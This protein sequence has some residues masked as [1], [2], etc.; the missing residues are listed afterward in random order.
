MAVSYSAFSAGLEKRRSK[1]QESA[2]AVPALY[3]VDIII[4]FPYSVPNDNWP[5]RSANAFTSNHILRREDLHQDSFG[6]SLS[7]IVLSIPPQTHQSL[8][9]YTKVS[10]S[11]QAALCITLCHASS[12]LVLRSRPLPTCWRSTKSFSTAQAQM[13]NTRKNC[14]TRNSR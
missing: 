6:T 8:R 14:G 11:E 4:R 2:L 7:E 1:W 12:R 3:L 13:C 9:Q 10:I 5:C